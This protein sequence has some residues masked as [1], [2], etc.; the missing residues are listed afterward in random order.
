VGPTARSLVEE[1]IRPHPWILRPGAPLHRLITAGLL[2]NRLRQGYGI[3]WNKRREKRFLLLAKTIRGL[4]PL[5]PKFLRVVP[6]AR[7]AE[8]TIR[9]SLTA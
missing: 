1:I 9:R 7:S 3:P 6:H 5:A 2:P 4:L 8:K